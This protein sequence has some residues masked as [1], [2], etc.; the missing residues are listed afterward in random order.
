[1]RLRY[2]DWEDDE[3][4]ENRQ[5]KRNEFYRVTGENFRFMSGYPALRYNT[6]SRGGC[7]EAHVERSRL[8]YR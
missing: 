5:V 6:T 2:A 1:M 7:E 8:E 4:V 3:F